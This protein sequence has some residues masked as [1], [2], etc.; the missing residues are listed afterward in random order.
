ML[1]HKWVKEEND[2]LYKRLASNKIFVKLTVMCE[3]L[4]VNHGLRCFLITITTPPTKTNKQ[5]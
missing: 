4:G 3:S 2:S 5:F 1:T